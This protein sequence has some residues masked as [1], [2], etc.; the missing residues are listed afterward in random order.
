MLTQPSNNDGQQ[1]PESDKSYDSATPTVSLSKGGEAIQDMGEK[2]AADPVAT[3][4]SMSATIATSP[5]RSRFGSQL[6]LHYNSD[7]GRI[8]VAR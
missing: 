5:G 6:S 3:K 8:E 7:V 2:L 4:G 1:V